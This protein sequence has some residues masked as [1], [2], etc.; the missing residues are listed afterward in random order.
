MYVFDV[1]KLQIEELS[2][3]CNLKTT[4]LIYVYLKNCKKNNWGKCLIVQT[5][6]ILLLCRT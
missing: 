5:K 4:T 3:C 1:F 2:L 6:K